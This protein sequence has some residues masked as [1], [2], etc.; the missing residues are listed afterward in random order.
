MHHDTQQEV[1]DA[2]PGA[3][4]VGPLEKR[5]KARAKLLVVQE[6]CSERKL[7]QYA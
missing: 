4:A 7:G 3:E 2:R 1:G 5:D 6:L